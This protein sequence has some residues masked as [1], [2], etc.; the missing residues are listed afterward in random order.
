MVAEAGRA[1]TWTA[2]DDQAFDMTVP[3]VG[4]GSFHPGGFNV[5]FADGSVRFIKYTINPPTLKALITRDGGEVI[6]GIATDA[7]ANRSGT[8]LTRG[9]RPVRWSFRLAIQGRSR[10]LRRTISSRLGGPRS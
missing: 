4:L 8:A 1:V 2:P 7:D 6:A 3:N 10:H 9:G 5:L